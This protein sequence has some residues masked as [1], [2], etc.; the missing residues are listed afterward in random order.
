MIIFY[1]FEFGMKPGSVA[2]SIGAPG[3]FDLGSSPGWATV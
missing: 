3:A 1:F 2:A